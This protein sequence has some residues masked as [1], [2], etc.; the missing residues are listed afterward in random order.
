MICLIGLKFFRDTPCPS[1][2]EVEASLGVNIDVAVE[3]SDVPEDGCICGETGTVQQTEE[4]AYAY[5]EALFGLFRGNGS[6]N[7]PRMITRV[8]LAGSG[9]APFMFTI[10]TLFRLPEGMAVTLH[11]VPS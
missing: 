6:S 2:D 11:F 4:R 10:A 1:K 3:M 7:N 5:G 9:S 8:I